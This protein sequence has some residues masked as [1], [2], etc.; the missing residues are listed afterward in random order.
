[1]ITRR[2][3]SYGANPGGT[4]TPAVDPFVV[5]S[6]GTLGG[7]P[8]T[9]QGSFLDGKSC[10]GLFSGKTS[11]STAFEQPADALKTKFGALTTT[12]I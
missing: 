12:A 5:R 10:A 9:V 7:V 6:V 1:M 11:I 8:T 3:T 2:R 4:F